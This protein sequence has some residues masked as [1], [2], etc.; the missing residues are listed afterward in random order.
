MVFNLK[1]PS[2]KKD[3]KRVG[4]GIGSGTGKTSGAGHKGQSA[5]SGVSI[6]GFE[7]GQT[8]LH[9]RLPKIGFTSHNVE[10]QTTYVMNSS[11]LFDLFESGKLDSTKLIDLD[12]LKSAG[13]VASKKYSK[14]KIIG[15]QVPNQPVSVKV[16]K[17]SE[18]C[19]KAIESAK[20]KVELEGQI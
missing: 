8:P 18:G 20:G 17:I 19:R 13:I 1:K 14:L 5:R 4:R 9:R 10:K 2:N 12:Y 3:R 15:A 16:H 6:K 11:D 7:G